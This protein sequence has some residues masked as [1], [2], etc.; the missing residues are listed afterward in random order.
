MVCLCFVLPFAAPAQTSAPAPL[1]PAAQELVKKGILAAKQQDYLLAARFFQDARK[2]APQ[3]PEI[4]Y[5]LGLAESNLPGRELRAICWFEAYL[6]ANPK[7]PNAAAVRDQVDVLDVKMQSNLSHLIKSLQDATG[8]LTDRKE[9]ALMELAHLWA[10][11]G[12]LTAAFN[13]VTLSQGA[14]NFK[15]RAQRTIAA[16]QADAG[17]VAG[18]KA[19]TD[20]IP[21]PFE[22][23]L[24]L[25]NVAEAQVKSEDLAGALRTGSSIQDE[26]VRFR[27][28]LLRDI[29]I[30]EVK[31]GDLAGALKSAGLISSESDAKNDAYNAIAGAQVHAEDIESA[32]KT[33]DLMRPGIYKASLLQDI[34]E[35]EA[36]AG[37]TSHALE[38]AESIQDGDYESVYKSKALSAIAEVQAKAGDTAGAKDTLRLARRAA[39]RSTDHRGGLNTTSLEHIAIAQARALGDIAGAQQTADLIASASDKSYALK[40]IAEAQAKAGDF[41]AA[42]KTAN[43]IIPDGTYSNWRGGT[44]A[45]IAEAQAE[46]GD[47]AG[48]FKTAELIQNEYYRK[49][50]VGRI[51][52]GQAKGRDIVGAL[53]TADLIHDTDDKSSA[54]LGIVDVQAESGDIAGAFKTADLIIGT[55][56]KSGALSY[57][58]SA[59]A[60]AGDA[61]NA[62]STF[63]LALKTAD[64]TPDPKTKCWRQRA[65]AA[66]QAKVGDIASARETLIIA[67]RTA[68]LI[69]DAGWKKIGLDAVAEDQRK[70]GSTNSASAVQVPAVPS[71]TAL[72]V[73]DWLDK[74]DETSAQSD[75]ALNSFP[76]LDFAGYLKSL[77]VTATPQ[78]AFDTLRAAVEK[79]VTAQDVVARM[80]RRQAQK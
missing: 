30:A 70:F 16:G 29:A 8:Q 80:M 78:A 18:A 49:S 56:E 37:S 64:L 54:L 59:Q 22:K 31:A 42:L 47:V 24:A 1:P 41:T 27:D 23:N 4:Y 39:D 61:A 14:N 75:C 21:D 11:T 72:S 50:G 60:K 3:A 13:I 10:K 77:P 73:P 32:H 52:H 76:F 28:P 20:L 45:G 74:L 15:S 7:A 34:A 66:A 55:D 62:K 35:L 68:N 63:T 57:I 40:E 43:C 46:A 25:N 44:L 19:T 38:T 71:V 17:D 2:M 67:L 33:A 36:K 58:A 9:D 5:D 48:A 69:Q 12:D 79:I 53:K 26:Y 6:M 65:I 51:V